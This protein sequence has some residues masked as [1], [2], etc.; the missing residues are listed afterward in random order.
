LAA[1]VLRDPIKPADI[2]L[3]NVLE[4]GSKI[5]KVDYIG[6]I[7]LHPKTDTVLKQTYDV[8]GDV[9]SLA[10]CTRDAVGNSEKW[11]RLCAMPLKT[12]HNCVACCRV[13][14]KD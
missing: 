4:T 5:L 13:R 6:I 12:K 10:R 1:A 2:D 9:V 14:V 7:Q 3:D 8:L 11:K